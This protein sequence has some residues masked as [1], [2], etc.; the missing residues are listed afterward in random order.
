MKGKRLSCSFND[1]SDE[2]SEL[3]SQN[4]RM[5]V[6]I[7]ARATGGQVRKDNNL[8]EQEGHGIL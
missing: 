8:S 7:L 1:D 6:R 3:K 4:H 5:Q 2:I